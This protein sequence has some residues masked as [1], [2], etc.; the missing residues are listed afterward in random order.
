MNLI[1]TTRIAILA[2]CCFCTMAIFAGE[3]NVNS[4]N[5]ILDG[6]DV[7]AY[8]QAAKAVKGS[9]KHAAV[10]DGVNFHFS[11]KE[12]LE[13]FEANPKK[14]LP[15]YHGYCAFAVGAKGAKVPADPKTFKLYNGA[16][17][18]F[19]NDLFEGKKFNTK[20]PWNANEKSL[21]MKAE[22]N[23]KDIGK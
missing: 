13:I 9:K 19:F 14:F 5:V 10:Y 8:F 1:K 18:I 15:K 7:V 4:K 2:I 6:Y 16:L 20:V 23:W 17:L 12:N 21:F 3:W 11:S 22:Q